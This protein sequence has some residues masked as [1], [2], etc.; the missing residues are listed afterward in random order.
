MNKIPFAVVSFLI[1]QAGSAI[2]FAS[3]LESRVSSIEMWD[4]SEQLEMIKENRRYIQEVVIPS[5]E[6]S[7]NWDN[8]HYNNWLKAGGWK[9]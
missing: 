5:Y 7:D 1:V 2:W 6:I 8:P 4:Y 3:Q 9:D